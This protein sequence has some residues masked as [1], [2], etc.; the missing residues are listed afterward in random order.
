MHASPNT[1]AAPHAVIMDG[2]WGG[3][4]MQLAAV[5]LAHPDK[6]RVLGATACFGNAPLADVLRNAGDVLYLLGVP[7]VPRYAGAEGP[8]GEP[9]PAGDDAFG[10]DGVGGVVLQ[11]NSWPP[12]QG[13]AVDFIL[14]TLR[15]EP[16][17]SVT[18]TATGPLTNIAQAIAREPATMARIQSLIVMGGCTQEMPAT[19]MPTRRGNITPHAEFN[20]YMAPRD[21]QAV[22][23]SGLPITLLPMNCTQQMTFTPE[24]EAAL[25]SRLARIPDAAEKVIAL[26]R[27]PAEIDRRKFNL[28]PTMHDVHTALFLLRPEIYEGRRGAVRVTTNGPDRGRADFTPNASG[29]VHVM[30]KLQNAARAFD[31]VLESF[32]KCVQPQE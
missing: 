10:A 14:E 9:A 21:A 25:R 7:Q 15:R 11:R 22:M 32:G 2:D 18:I 30:E 3:D 31:I 24:R 13:H 1:G 16:A 12:Q 29:S 27:A 5:L 17:N 8:T 6:A 4:E 20:F 26:L 19:D 28:S 23:Q